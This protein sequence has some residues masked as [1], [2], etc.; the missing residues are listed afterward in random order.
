M[1]NLYYYELGR[2]GITKLFK[3]IFT[4]IKSKN[5]PDLDETLEDPVKNIQP[6]LGQVFKLKNNNKPV[7][8][9]DNAHFISESDHMSILND[10]ANEWREVIIILVGDNMDNTLP[11]DFTPFSLNPWNKPV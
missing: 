3:D 6:Y 10:M 2:E 4:F 5:K 9:L 8:I 11:G 7:L 1:Y